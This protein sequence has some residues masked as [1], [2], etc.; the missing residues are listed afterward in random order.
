MDSVYGVGDIGHAPYPDR[1]AAPP[2]RTHPQRLQGL[3]IGTPGCQRHTV[4]MRAVNAAG[5]GESAEV[6]GTPRDGTAP[7]LSRATLTPVFDEALDEDS[8]LAAQAFAVEVNATARGVDTVA[9]TLRAPP[10]PRRP[11][12][13]RGPDLRLHL[14]TRRYPCLRGARPRDPGRRLGSGSIASRNTRAF[15][16]G[17]LLRACLALA[18]HPL[19]D[20]FTVYG[21]QILPPFSA[22][23]V[24]WSTIFII[25]PAFSVPV[26]LGVPIA[27]V[28]ARGRGRRL[29]H[30]GLAIGAAWLALTLVIKAHVERV[31]GNSPTAGRDPLPHHADAVQRGALANGRDDRR[32]AVSRGG[33]LAGR[34]GAAGVGRE[35]AGRP[36]AARGASEPSGGGS[37]HAVPPG[38][39]SALRSG[40]MVLSDLRSGFEE[41]LVFSFVV[42]RREGEAIEPAPICRRPDADF[43]PGTWAKRDSR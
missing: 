27:R 19:L 28:F 29:N 6:T 3:R 30:A 38:V 34:R 17:W 39:L 40:E 33:L 23:P 1:A 8:R 7:A 14:A 15:R 18:T 4:R 21:T 31:S 43:T 5:A 24:G 42:A 26:L 13:D 32:W 37:P 2:P 25:D 41:R 16:R 9:T 22:L 35:P 11:R 36:R 20:C 12:S 10:R